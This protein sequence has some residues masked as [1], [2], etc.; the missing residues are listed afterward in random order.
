MKHTEFTVIC[1]L[2]ILTGASLG[3]AV[4]IDPAEVEKMFRLPQDDWLDLELM[5]TKAGYA[6]IYMD[7]ARFYEH[8][9]TWSLK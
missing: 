3:G 8:A 1:L 9:L 2:S 7:N 5:G 4:D 6:H